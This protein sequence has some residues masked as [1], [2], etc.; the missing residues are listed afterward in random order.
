M[1]SPHS[2]T[3]DRVQ[4]VFMST[5]LSAPLSNQIQVPFITTRKVY[6]VRERPSRMYSWTA[7]ITSQILGELPFNVLGSSIYFLIWYWLVGFDSSRAGYTYLMIGVVYPFYYTTIAQAV[8]AMSPN[9]EIA[10]LLFSFLFSFVVTFNGVLQPFRQL[11]WWRWMYRL[12]PYTY[13]I[14]GLIGQAVGRSQVRCSDVE[15]VQLIPPSGQSCSTFM[16]PYIQNAGGY[17]LNADAT[18]S[19]NFCY[20][21]SSDTFLYSSFNIQY[22]NHWRNFGLMWAYVIFN[23]SFS[24]KRSLLSLSLTIVHRSLGSSPRRGSSASVASQRSRTGSFAANRLLH[25]YHPLCHRLRPNTSPCTTCPRHS[26]ICFPP[27]SHFPTSLHSRLPFIIFRDVALNAH[28]HAP[29][30]HHLYIFTYYTGIIDIRRWP[31]RGTINKHV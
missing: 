3:N 27:C 1:Q 6:E 8:A 28:L 7:L 18:D 20:I 2:S 5:I 9:P 15:I 14:E 23:V 13:L 10:A 16:A 12:S 29:R 25:R 17:L 30:H 11:G 21:S 24:S 26:C 4:A 31:A 22:S 19:C